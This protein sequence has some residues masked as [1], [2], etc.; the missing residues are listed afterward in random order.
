[1]E[2]T[3]KLVDIREEVLQVLDKYSDY[4]SKMWPDLRLNRA[5]MFVPNCLGS[6]SFFFVFSFSFTNSIN[7]VLE[8]F[9]FKAFGQSHCSDRDL[10]IGLSDFKVQFIDPDYFT[11]CYREYN[12]KQFL[13]TVLTLETYIEQSAFIFTYTSYIA[14]YDKAIANAEKKG[15]FSVS[16]LPPTDV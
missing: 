4:I 13:S 9:Q 10:L 3:V 16:S 6:R 15:Y 5:D 7:K 8:D 11:T 12:L 1:M 2:N 14:N